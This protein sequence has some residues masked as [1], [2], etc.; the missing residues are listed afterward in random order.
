MAKV[1]PTKL[2]MRILIIHFLTL[3]TF[4]LFAAEPFNEAFY[5]VSIRKSM[6]AQ[7]TEFG[8]SCHNA[9][10]QALAESQTKANQQCNDISED[11]NKLSH[12]VLDPDFDLIW[13]SASMGGRQ[14]YFCDVTVQSEYRC[15]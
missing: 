2:N 9:I 1:V 4:K 7:S 3:F 13:H 15:F 10:E 12:A 5:S 14:A 11:K 8:K 6:A